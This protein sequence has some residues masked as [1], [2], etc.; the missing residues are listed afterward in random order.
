[1]IDHATLQECKGAFIVT[2][3]FPPISIP[4]ENHTSISIEDIEMT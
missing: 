2:E 1:M 4:F 3:R